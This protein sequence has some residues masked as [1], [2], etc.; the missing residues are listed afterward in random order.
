MSATVPQ[1]VSSNSYRNSVIE[2]FSRDLKFALHS[3]RFEPIEQRVMQAPWMEP[4]RFMFTS[5]RGEEANIWSIAYRHND[6]GYMNHLREEAQERENWWLGFRA[7]GILTGTPDNEN[8]DGIHAAVFGE[9]SRN[10]EYRRYDW[11]LRTRHKYK[12]Y[13]S[14]ELT[15]FAKRKLRSLS[16]LAGVSHYKLD[17]GNGKSESYSV[18]ELCGS[19]T[20]DSDDSD[21]NVEARPHVHQRGASLY[22]GVGSDSMSRFETSDR[23]VE[24]NTASTLGLLQGG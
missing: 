3:T 10:E 7:I 12:Q 23:Q 21:F 8:D 5:M 1:T 20:D 19:G 4:Q 6:M 18:E 22:H 13:M 2:T 17:I 14:T 16:R 11:I 15:D 9:I 24:T